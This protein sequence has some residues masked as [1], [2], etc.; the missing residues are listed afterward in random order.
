MI[1]LKCLQGDEVVVGVIC[2][3]LVIAGDWEKK[4][5][6]RGREGMRKEVKGR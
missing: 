3:V 5:E 6:G 2:K 1:A 4:G